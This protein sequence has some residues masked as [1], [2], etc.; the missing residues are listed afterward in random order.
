MRCTCASVWQ[1]E[2]LARFQ[3][4]RRPLFALLLHISSAG[5]E[6]ENPYVLPPASDTIASHFYLSN[7]FFNNS[8]AIFNIDDDGGGCVLCASDTSAAESALS[9]LCVYVFFVCV[10]ARD[11]FYAML[12]LLLCFQCEECRLCILAFD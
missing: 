3:Q 8:L 5:R 10:C 4:R 2:S 9:V 11:A 1:V 7:Y 12:S 6:R